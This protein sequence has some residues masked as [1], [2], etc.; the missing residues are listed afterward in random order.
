MNSCSFELGLLVSGKSEERLMG[1]GLV[2]SSSRGLFRDGQWW[3]WFQATKRVAV[4][5]THV[6][7]VSF[8]LVPLQWHTIQETLS[9]S[10]SPLSKSHNF[11]A[12][13]CYRRPSM[14]KPAFPR[15]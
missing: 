9:G 1:N 2:G 8:A 3:R 10:V 11:F 15:D 14:A 7:F 5:T 4:A 12:K 6:L 13:K